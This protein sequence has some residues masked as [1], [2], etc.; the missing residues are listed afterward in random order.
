MRYE[1]ETFYLGYFCC[2]GP[3][4]SETWSEIRYSY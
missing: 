3:F 2:L 1:N 4:L